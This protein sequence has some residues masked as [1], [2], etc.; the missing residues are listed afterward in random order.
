MEVSN[1]SKSDLESIHKEVQ[2]HNM[3][4][5][6]HCVRLHQSIKTQSNIY[7]MQDYCNAFDLSMLLRLRGR[8]SQIE[9]SQILR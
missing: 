5:S 9:V 1:I 4:K 7:M 3:V 6:D 2:I 8:V